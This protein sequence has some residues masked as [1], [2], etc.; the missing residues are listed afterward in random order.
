MA[1][2]R[3]V[4]Y[5]CWSVTCKTFFKVV[6]SL[7]FTLIYFSTILFKMEFQISVLQFRYIDTEI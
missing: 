5:L 1:G 7:D 6:N 2:A 3:I 4:N